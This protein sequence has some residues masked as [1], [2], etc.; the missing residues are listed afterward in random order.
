[1]ASPRSP[2]CPISAL[3]RYL[4]LRPRVQGPLFINADQVPITRSWFSRMLK[5]CL[6]IAGFPVH[7]YNTHSFRLGRAT[8]LAIA[9]TPDHIIQ[10]TGR[11]KSSAFLAYIRFT[12]VALPP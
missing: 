2:I 1:M 8:D 3:L 4:R 12:P 5:R 6:A 7:A 9:G 11:W 10:K